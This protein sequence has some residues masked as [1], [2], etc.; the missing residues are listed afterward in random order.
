MWVRGGD[1]GGGGGGEEDNVLAVPRNATDLP[2]VAYVEI[3]ENRQNAGLCMCVQSIYL[4]C[5]IP[6]GL[7][8]GG[9]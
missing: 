4:S 3:G 5:C 8:H 1:G 2:A 9:N 6:T 7:G